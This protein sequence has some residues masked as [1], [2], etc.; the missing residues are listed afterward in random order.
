MFSP[1]PEG[2]LKDPIE[3][4]S[5]QTEESVSRQLTQLQHCWP[6]QQH[7]AETGEYRIRTE[8]GRRSGPSDLLWIGRARPR[9]TRPRSNRLALGS[10]QVQ[11]RMP[12]KVRSTKQLTL[13]RPRCRARLPTRA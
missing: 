12:T 2:S 6:H 8:S 11:A 13:I 9:K 5:L 1:S 3:E 4:Y 10:R 7:Q